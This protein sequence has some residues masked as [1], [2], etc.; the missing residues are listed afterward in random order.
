[1]I[2]RRATS[3]SLCFQNAAA[4]ILFHTRILLPCLSSKFFSSF[5]YQQK[6][7]HTLHN[8]YFKMAS[9]Y[10]ATQ[11]TANKKSYSHFTKSAEKSKIKDFIKSFNGKTLSIKW[12]DEFQ[13][14]FHSVWLRHNC[15]C[16]SCRHPN[17]Q[18]LLDPSSVQTSTY[19]AN[20]SLEGDNLNIIWTNSF[21][22]H[23]GIVPLNFL[24]RH[25]YDKTS[26]L[27]R[28]QAAKNGYPCSKIPNISFSEVNSS[29]LGLLKLLQQI[30]E[31]GLSIIEGVPLED[32]KVVEIANLI[33][34]VEATI[35]GTTFDVE[36][37]KEPINVAYSNLEIDLHQDLVYYESPPGLQLLHCLKF[38]KSV[39]GGESIFLDVFHIADQFR[40]THP[41]LFKVLVEVPA[42]FQKVHYN[43]D[44][45]VHILNQKP[46]IKLNHNGEI[47]AVYWAP[48]FEGPL[49]V[50]EEDVELYYTAYEM[51]AKTVKSSPN[52]L[53]HRLQPG[54]LV[55]FNNQRML[56][57]RT[58]F[59]T[60]G[61]LRHLK[62]CY[63]NIDVFKSRT[64][65][66]NNLYGDKRLA[67]RVGNQCWF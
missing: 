13:S 41:D 47:V 42:T 51:F 17:G 18:R 9:F 6:S 24:R 55:I 39:Q 15:H 61:G 66:Y 53:R 21:G 64:Q 43:R 36:V 54:Q 31:D 4:R 19:L 50:A 58:G 48:P 63:I 3:L 52:L 33:G 44:Y 56:H 67:K 14:E 60:N 25:T 22:Q 5:Q 11:L 40:L 23:H 46:H 30:N 49:S 1:M 62:G 65:V 10:I 7:T 57:G 38:D 59:Q 35:Y 26:L 20:L 16:E 29:S 2:M 34:P 45:P 8:K 12:E 37:T 27:A 32:L 28:R